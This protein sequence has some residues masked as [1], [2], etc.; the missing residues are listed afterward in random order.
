MAEAEVLRI[1][2]EVFDK[3]EFIPQYFIQIN[4]KHL[5]DALFEIAG[6]RDISTRY[7][8]ND[9]VSQLQRD[10]WSIVT[11]RLEKELGLSLEVIEDLKK[12]FQLKGPP[13]QVSS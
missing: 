7:A 8:I 3:F 11:I 13:K 2:T 4:H 10:P 6:I 1:A 9:I 12:A 5:N